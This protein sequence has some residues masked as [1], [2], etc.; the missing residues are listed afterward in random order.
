MLRTIV[1][2]EAIQM[3]GGLLLAGWVLA[4]HWATGGEAVGSLL[5]AFWAL[6]LPV[7]GSL[8]SRQLAM[9]PLHRSTFLRLTEPLGAVEAKSDEAESG[10]SLSDEPN[11]SVTLVPV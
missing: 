2:A 5:L 8:L 4:E 10:K 1:A 3:V 9:F 6:Q 7:L 11:G